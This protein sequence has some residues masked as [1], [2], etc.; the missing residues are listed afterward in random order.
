[1]TQGT[2]G[3]G[4]AYMQGWWDCA[5]L[6]ELFNKFCLVQIK[7]RVAVHPESIKNGLWAYF[8]NR[9]SK[10]WLQK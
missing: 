7:S 2:L 4:E 10:I 9:Q 6:D 5:Q 3:L 1:M 8:I